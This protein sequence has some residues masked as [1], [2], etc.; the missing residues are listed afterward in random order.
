[1]RSFRSVLRELIDGFRSGEVVLDRGEN[2]A[3]SS[4]ILHARNNEGFTAPSACPQG[5]HLVEGL[6]LEKDGSRQDA[7]VLDEGGEVK[8]DYLLAGESVEMGI[9]LPS[10]EQMEDRETWAEHLAWCK[11]R[12]LEY[13][14]RG[15]L[16]AAVSSMISDLGKHPDGRKEIYDVLTMAG[17]MEVQNGPSAVRHWVEGFN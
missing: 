5:Y 9:M 11:Q 10:R 6:F 8:I 16:A 4:T 17:M 7:F 1:M 2:M 12:A 13:V 3:N 14:D 15:E